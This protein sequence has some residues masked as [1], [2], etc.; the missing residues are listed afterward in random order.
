[1]LE[2]QVC[3]IG[4]AGSAQ[5]ARDDRRAETLERVLILAFAMIA[6][7]SLLWHL[8]IGLHWIWGSCGVH[9]RA[10]IVQSGLN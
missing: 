1:M 8:G 5:Q 4:D 7:T 9:L 2:A 3:A 10:A 6:G